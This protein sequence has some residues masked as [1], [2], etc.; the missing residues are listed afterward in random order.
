M[1][2]RDAGSRESGDREGVRLKEGNRTKTAKTAE[3][4]EVEATKKIQSNN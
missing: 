3:A 4:V 1:R 2:K